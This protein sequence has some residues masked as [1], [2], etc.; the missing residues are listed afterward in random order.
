MV[1]GHSSNMYT[2][3]RSVIDSLNRG[4]K[5][6]ALRVWGRMHG[7]CLINAV[8]CLSFFLYFFLSAG[9]TDVCLLVSLPVSLSPCLC[10]SVFVYLF[11]CIFVFVYKCLCL[12]LSLYDCLSVSLLSLSLSLSYFRRFSTLI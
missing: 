5:D 7:F 8:L 1:T 12:S 9:F 2:V 3:I 6:A 10:L 11:V 4:E